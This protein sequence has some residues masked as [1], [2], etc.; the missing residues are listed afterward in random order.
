MN[1]TAQRN[2]EILNAAGF[3][4]LSHEDGYD[5]VCSAT[6]FAHVFNNGS[7]S[8]FVLGADSDLLEDALFA[9]MGPHS[10]KKSVAQV[11]A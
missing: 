9:G 10:L 5:L 4:P 2:L 8:I 11:R 7:W 1:A 3:A 6:H